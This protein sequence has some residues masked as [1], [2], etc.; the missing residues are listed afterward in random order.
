MQ[1][2]QTLQTIPLIFSLMPVILIVGGLALGFWLGYWDYR[3]KKLIHEERRLMIERG[4][5]PPPQPEPG[6]NTPAAA[7]SI[8]NKLDHEERRLMIEKG[9]TPP[10]PK[11]WGWH[12]YLRIGLVA[13][14]LGIGLA[15]AYIFLA[16]SGDWADAGPVGAWGAA[17]GMAGLGLIIYSLIAKADKP[18]GGAQRPR[19]A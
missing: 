2:L 18:E 13:F 19:S 10:P 8:K 1:A 9:L 6:A 11:R 5:T 15:I 3:K 7:W 4:M 17:I 14:F 12:E 16:K